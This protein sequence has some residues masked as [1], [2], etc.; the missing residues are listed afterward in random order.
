MMHVLLVDDDSETCALLRG[1]L[2]RAGLHVH[3]AADAD[4]ASEVL[5]RQPV[6]VIVLDV[7][8]P[9]ESG[10]SLCARWR[11]EGLYTPILFLS[12][13]G[14]VAAR[15]DG[16]EAGGDDYLAKP[17]AVRELLAR[18]RALTRRGPALR[19]RRLVLGEVTLELAQRRA[20]RLG[21][22]VP[23]TSREWEVLEAL[24]AA[25][26]GPLR[27]DQLLEAAWGDVSDE[28]RASLEVIVSR[29]RR[30]LDVPGHPSLI[31]TLRGHGYALPA[32]AAPHDP[33]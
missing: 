28:A 2:E 31:R 27:F 8:L 22:E 20:T 12:A 1:A 4:A 14:A 29:L 18:V 19:P 11:S 3:A 30:K 17:F 5:A 13:R 23:L 25:R 9:G 6:D 26:G 21:L 16:L 10:L 33:P 24:A 7:M 32:A 15:V